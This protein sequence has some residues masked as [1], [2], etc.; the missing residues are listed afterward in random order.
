[1]KQIKTILLVTGIAAV[2]AGCATQGYRQADSTAAYLR[3][4]SDR[5]LQAVTQVNTATTSLTDLVNQPQGDLKLQFKT[6]SSAVDRL[7]SVSRDV[8]SR[9][10]VIQQ[11]GA[12]YFQ[13]WDEELAT[14]QNED[15]RN[16]SANRKAE[17]MKEFDRAKATYE[18]ARADFN[19]LMAD[20]RDLR[21]ALS[22]DLTPAGA[23]A[24]RASAARVNRK[25]DQVQ[26]TL[27]N[28]AAQ[29]RDLSQSLAVPPAPPRAK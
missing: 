11:K 29:L 17:V 21:T 16:S 7:D 18:E 3:S 4:T 23:E 10:V 14:I 24:V 15:I 8:A 25:G 20:L 6:F 2:V 27:S 13:K 28:L 26:V 5:V 12:T 9:A 22:T 1:M 19:P